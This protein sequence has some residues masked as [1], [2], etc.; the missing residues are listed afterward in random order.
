M[1]TYPLGQ[2]RV[3]LNK[4]GV[5][6]YVKVGFPVRYGLFSEIET[7]DTLFQFNLNGE[8]KFIQ[9]RGPHGLP[10]TEWLKRISIPFLTCWPVDG[11][12]PV[13]REPSTSHLLWAEG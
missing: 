7:E 3:T 12:L 10:P 5:K 11:L 1:E 2:L 9:G 13:I 4:E 8:I 6:E